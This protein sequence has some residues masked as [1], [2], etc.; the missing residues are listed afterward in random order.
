MAHHKSPIL[1]RQRTFDMK[2]KSATLWLVAIAVVLGAGVVIL[3]TQRSPESATQGQGGERLFEV[4][5]RDIQAVTLTTQLRTLRFERD[6]AGRWQLL[7]PEPQPANDASVAFLLNLLVSG[8]SDRTLSV[9]SSDWEVFGFHQPMAVID[10]TLA[11]ESE[12][13]SLTIGGYDFNRSALYAHR[14]LPPTAPEG[15][16]ML[17][18][19]LVTPSF[20]DAVNRPLDD[21]KQLDTGESPDD[22]EA[23]AVPAEELGEDEAGTTTDAE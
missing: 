8:E 17:D 4:E 12:P 21:W 14:D 7:D 11:G 10:M 20:D 5:E 2:F 15:L 18:V 22:P 9:P 19:L 3:E 13:R 1:I 23:D 6:E 16:D